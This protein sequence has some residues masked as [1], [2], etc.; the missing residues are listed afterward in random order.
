MEKERRFV[1][2]DVIQ[3]RHQRGAPHRLVI[4]ATED[5]DVVWVHDPERDIIKVFTWSHDLVTPASPETVKEAA[6]RAELIAGSP[7]SS[8]RP[9][10]GNKS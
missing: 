2:G 7:W 4:G 5:P 1:P 10:H 9:R 3:Q 6:E 8:G